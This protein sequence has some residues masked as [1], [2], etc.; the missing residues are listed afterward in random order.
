LDSVSPD[1]KDKIA[2]EI[3]DAPTHDGIPVSPY[4]R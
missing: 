4:A 3:H 2:H 1:R